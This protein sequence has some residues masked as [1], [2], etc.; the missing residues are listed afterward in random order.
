MFATHPDCNYGV[1]FSPGQFAIDP[2]NKGD[3]DGA[4]DLVVLELTYEPLPPTTRVKTPNGTHIYFKGDAANS[5]GKQSLGGGIDVRGHDPKPG[6]VVGPGSVID[7]KAYELIDNTE[8]AEA[9]EWLLG[10]TAK[11]IVAPAKRAPGVDVDAPHE[12]ASVREYLTRLADQGA[13]AEAYH[14]GNQQTYE[15]ACSVLDHVSPE[16]ALELLAEVWNPRCHPPWSHDELKTIVANAEKYRQNEIGSSASAAPSETF[17]GLELPAAEAEVLPPLVE[18]PSGELS[19]IPP[20]KLV[21]DIP[22]ADVGSYG[23]VKSTAANTRI[24]LQTI[25]INCGFDTF[26]GFPVIGGQPLNNWQGDMTDEITKR[27]CSFVKQLFGFEPVPKIME[28][29]IEQLCFENK[30]NPITDYLDSLKWDGVKRLDTWTIEHFGTPDTLLN[31]AIGR[32]MLIAAVARAQHP[33]CKFD[34][35]VVLESKE[36]WNKS[37]ALAL[38]AGQKYFS[39]MSLLRENEKTQAEH[40]RGKWIYEI[41]DLNG[42]SKAD[43][44]HVKAMASRQIDRVRRVWGHF[45][46]DQL[47][48]AILTATTNDSDYLE[49]DTGQR[50]F[51]PIRV[52][53]IID[54][55]ALAAVRDQ[56][57][58]EAAHAQAAGESIRLDESLWGDAE[59][60]QE[61]RR[62]T[63]PWEDILAQ[64]HGY[65]SPV[66]SDWAG[67]GIILNGS[68]ADYHEERIHSAEVLTSKLDIEISRQTAQQGKIAK[69]IMLRL[70]WQH[71]INLHMGAHQGKGYW[72]VVE[73]PLPEQNDGDIVPATGFNSTDQAEIAAMLGD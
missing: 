16:V 25:G 17:A 63:H 66:I 28:L 32:L 65:P 72:R 3:R 9:P 19:L 34:E 71:T 57:W 50:R 15:L 12:V 7:G 22:W 14:G 31:R 45:E 49:G 48:T 54:L 24:A 68:P 8:M 42:L 73:G 56:L 38:M 55:V 10:L 35:I 51:W 41:A 26:R 2:D 64:V 37:S 70:G 5:V 18:S 69:R 61:A 27:L 6:Y 1:A 33:G 47:R 53:R 67:A 21:V 29:A 13:V 36:G 59:I 40:L 43:R 52:T 11:Q 20:T 23:L 62:L 39:D 30:F 4:G 46:L 58:A 60:E 44:D